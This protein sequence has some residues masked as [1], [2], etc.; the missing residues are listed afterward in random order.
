MPTATATPGRHPSSGYPNPMIPETSQSYA[1]EEQNEPDGDT[2]AGGADYGWPKL[3]HFMA[4]NPVV[5]C[6]SRFELLNM[7]TLLYYQVELVAL[8]AELEQQEK[9]DVE[10]IW[11]NKGDDYAEKPDN[12][13]QSMM[14]MHSSQ[15]AKK[16]QWQIIMRIRK[17][18][19]EYSS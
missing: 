10:A 12:L 1:P 4:E 14:D 9:N 11:A 19:T 5:R 6:F 7:K 15:L 18:M 3:A 13:I 2:T 17:T 8:Q 16:P